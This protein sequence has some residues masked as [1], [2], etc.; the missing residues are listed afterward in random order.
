MESPYS[1]CRDFESIHDI[2]FCLLLVFFNLSRSHSQTLCRKRIKGFCVLKKSFI[3]INPDIFKYCPD[4]VFDFRTAPRGPL[5]EKL[6][7]ELYI[8]LAFY[9]LHH[10]NWY[11]PYPSIFLIIFI[12]HLFSDLFRLYLIKLLDS[13]TS[14][15]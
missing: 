7:K 15:E 10:C 9:N 2:F 8:F 1:L 11:P 4:S 12:P 3:T 13:E 6:Q 5:P 14:S